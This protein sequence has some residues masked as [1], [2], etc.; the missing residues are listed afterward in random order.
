[1]KIEALVELVHTVAESVQQLS[2]LV[3]GMPKVLDG[4]LAVIRETL[5]S[6]AAA[7]RGEVLALRGEF[8]ALQ[9][10][11]GGLKAAYDTTTATMRGEFA[12]IIGDNREEFG[13]TVQALN[14]RIEQLAGVMDTR[15]NNLSSSFEGTAGATKAALDGLQGEFEALSQRVVVDHA[16]LDTVIKEVNDAVLVLDTGYKLLSGRTVEILNAVATLAPADDVTTLRT[17]VQSLDDRVTLGLRYVQTT[18]DEVRAAETEAASSLSDRVGLIDKVFVEASNEATAAIKAVEVRVQAVAES[19]SSLRQETG[20]NIRQVRE[21]CDTTDLHHRVKTLQITVATGEEGHQQLAARV[22]ETGVALTATQREVTALLESTSTVQTHASERLGRLFEEVNKIAGRIG[23]VEP[24]VEQFSTIE[25]AIG[26][27]A[28]RVAGV[29][30]F[31][32]ELSRQVAANGETL[33]LAITDFKALEMETRQAIAGHSGELRSTLDETRSALEARITVVETAAGESVGELRRTIANLAT[34]EA[35][36]TAIDAATEPLVASIAAVEVNSR[37]GHVALTERMNALP[38]RDEV[39]NVVGGTVTHKEFGTLQD[40]LNS[41]WAGFITDVRGVVDNV[42]MTTDSL[43]ASL[44]VL[45]TDHTKLAETVATLPTQMPEFDTMPLKT[46]LMSWLGEQLVEVKEAAV[47]MPELGLDVELGDDNSMLLTFNFGDKQVTRKV[48]L[49][50]GVEYK[51]VYSR[52]VD[53]V[54]GNFVTHKGSTWFAKG[55]PTG[56]PG[57]D[58]TGWQLAVKCGRDGRDATPTRAYVGHETGR[59]YR[60]TDFLRLNNRL[61][62]CTVKE[63][64]LVPEPGDISSTRQWTLI[65]PVQ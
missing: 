44:T 10:D 35:M 43:G 49:K 8:G 63:T 7:V 22:N 36:Q 34:T 13:V 15:V 52:D 61:W 41:R 37:A 47:K 12:Q 14:S 57:K 54:A 6:D 46:E 31:A 5:R 39:L 9:A 48:P 21:A 1:M 25:A 30:A 53:Y 50:I 55:R 29:D 16:A 33:G 51:G 24:L 3:E 58:I 60:E 38:T 40:E 19:V 2:S 45:S 65:G 62:Q 18:L 42:R 28:V 59:L 4:K 23:T 17:H 56:E 64:D 27:F 32:Q 20:D 26:D 11:V